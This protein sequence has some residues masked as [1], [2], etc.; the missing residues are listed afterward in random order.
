MTLS[1][2]GRS[3]PLAGPLAETL[4]HARPAVDA[5]LIQWDDTGEASSA[6]THKA[7]V[8]KRLVLDFRIMFAYIPRRRSAVASPVEAV[9]ESATEPA[10][11]PRAEGAEERP[12]LNAE[13]RT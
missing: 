11:D 2:L 10:L 1:P 12:S 6:R 4:C 8:A 5:I 7:L 13:P 3:A 9:L